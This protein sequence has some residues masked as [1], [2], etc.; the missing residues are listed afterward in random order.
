MTLRRFS[1]IGVALVATSVALAGCGQAPGSDGADAPQADACVRMV[2]N[3]GGL[4]DRSFNQSSWEGLQ[5]AE[6]EYGVEAEALVSTGETDLAPNV[7][8]AVDS[9]CELIVTVG[10]EL[11]EATLEAPKDPW[12]QA[13]RGRG[14]KQGVH[15]EHLSRLLAEM[16]VLPRTY[17]QA[18][19]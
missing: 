5:Q 13:T 3:S 18:R 14:G 1:T 9:G 7:Q 11:A 8:Q 4:E 2:T 19:W 6:Q 12:M 15:T 10:W 17:P 16:Q